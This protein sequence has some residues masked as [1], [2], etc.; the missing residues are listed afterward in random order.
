MTAPTIAFDTRAGFQQQLRALVGRTRTQLEMFDPDFSLF[1]LGAS[2]V[3][4][5]LRQALAGGCRLQLAM[6]DEGH[7]RR[8][9]PRLLRLLRDYA[10]AA[11]CRV[12]PRGLRHLTDS[13]AIG[14]EMHIVRR[15]HS[16][17]MRGV[18]AFD[19]P[20]ETDLQRER[21]TAIW[22]ESLPGLRAVTTGL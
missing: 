3:D 8:H 17:H 20:A 21:F 5:A 1:D 7:L 19:S 18:A 11:E 14:D 12:T 9:A 4:A 22:A 13:C 10:H 2:D 16:D 15:F 6:H